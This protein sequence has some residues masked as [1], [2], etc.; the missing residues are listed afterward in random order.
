MKNQNKGSVVATLIG[1]IVVAFI[2]VLYVSTHVDLL[3][4]EPQ[5]LMEHISEAGAPEKDTYVSI[6]VDAVVECYAETKHTINGF[7]PAGTD[8]HYLLWLDDGSFISL[9]AKGKKDIEKLNSI[10]N[11]TQKYIFGNADDLPAKYELNGVI[12]TM[13]R[14][15]EDY[16]RQALSSWDID[17]SVGKIYYVQIDETQG[18]LGAWL[19]VGFLVIIEIIIIIGFIGAVQDKKQEKLAAKA[20]AMNAP[21]TDENNNLYR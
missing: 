17:S 21:I 6:G 9:Q 13:D 1:M 3:L 8:T 18:K 2:I 10:M 11:Q 12:T 15:I 14:E 5:D 20:V 7:I 4:H 16:Y 19:M